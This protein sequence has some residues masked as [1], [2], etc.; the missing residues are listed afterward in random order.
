M[1]ESQQLVSQY[2]IAKRKFPSTEDNIP[3]KIVCLDFESAQAP[4]KVC[5]IYVKK[6]YCLMHFCVLGQHFTLIALLK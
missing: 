3:K 4:H 1:A 6:C 5:I 2:D